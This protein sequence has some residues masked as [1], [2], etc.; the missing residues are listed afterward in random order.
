MP[1][2]AYHSEKIGQALKAAEKSINP[3]GRSSA[4]RIQSSG[5]V[6]GCQ[7]SQTESTA[8]GVRLTWGS[9][10]AKLPCT[11]TGISVDG[12]LGSVNDVSTHSEG[13]HPTSD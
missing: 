2:K 8:L 13:G 11:N 10:Q 9:H 12:Y 6:T 5:R 3:A 1:V 4:R 7:V